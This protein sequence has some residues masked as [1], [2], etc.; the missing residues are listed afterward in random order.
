MIAQDGDSQPHRWRL[1]NDVPVSHLYDT[2]THR[3]SFRIVGD[4]DDGL[5]ESVVQLLEHVKDKS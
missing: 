5:I 3:R 2:F 4:H 1:F